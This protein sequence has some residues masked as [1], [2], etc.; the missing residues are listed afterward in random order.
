MKSAMRVQAVSLRRG[1]LSYSQILQQVPV[2]KSTLSIWLRSVGLS[3]R[4]QQRLTRRKVEA[5][6]RGAKKRNT[7]RLER[8]YKIYSDARKDIKEISKRELWL[9]GIMLYWAEGAKSKPHNVSQGVIFSNSDPYMVKLFLRWLQESVAISDERIA[10]E[11]YV[12]EKRKDEIG[13]FC[14]YWASCTGFLPTRFSKIYLKKDKIGTN[15]KNVNE[16]YRGLL[17]IRV[18]RSTDLNR[19]I[20]AWVKGICIQCGVV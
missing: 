19:K 17:R 12:H 3:Q 11:I 4:Q 14:A 13:T 18:L 2:A 16:N 9:M 7:Q 15:R 10:F 5:G 20:S 6:K 1:G 8:T